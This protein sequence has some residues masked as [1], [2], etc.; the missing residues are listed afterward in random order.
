VLGLVVM[1]AASPALG[2]LSDQVAESHCWPPQRLACSGSSG[3]AITY[4]LGSA[5]FGGPAPLAAAP[6]TQ[7][8]GNPLLPV[9]YATTM[10][11]VAAIGILP[12]RE[13]AFQPLDAGSPQADDVAWR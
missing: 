2:R 11:L 6:L 5:L 12:M 8:T 3:L 1:A 4:G 13:T 9:Y 7:R 10:A